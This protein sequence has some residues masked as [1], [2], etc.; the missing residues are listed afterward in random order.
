MRRLTETDLRAWMS[1]SSRKPLMLLGARQTG[2]TFLLR[3][4]LGPLFPASHYFSLDSNRI[5]AS[6]FDDEDLSPGRVIA[7][8]EMVGGRRI[9]SSRDLLILDEIQDCPRALASLKQFAQEMPGAFVCCA[10]S[11]LGLHLSDGTFP[12]GKVEFLDVR[13]MCFTEYLEA[14]DE[15]RLLEA[16]SGLGEGLKPSEAAHLLLWERFATYMLT[17]GMPEAVVAAIDRRET[18]LEAFQAARRIHLALETGYMAD[19][20]KHTGKPGS[21]QIERVWR[22]IPPQLGRTIDGNASR[23]RFSGVIPGKSGY[24]DLAGSIDWIEKAALAIRVPIVENAET[25][26]A[27]FARENAFKLYLHDTG[28]LCSMAGVGSLDGLQAARGSYR[29]WIAE[30]AV[31]Q[32][33]M[34]AGVRRPYSW[35]RATA[36]VEFLLEHDGKTIPVEV[37]A[38]RNSQAKSL[39]SFA[40]RYDPPL[41]IKAGM[42]NFSRRARTVLLPLYACSLLGSRVF[43]D[44]LMSGAPGP[45]S[46]S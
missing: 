26:L 7:G 32:E 43:L 46:R 29:G 13:P 19:M 42:W 4:Y 40:A 30:S 44:M 37:K 25:P 9:D 36:E 28:M 15:G 3:D 38:G 16:V 10:G 17:G 8:L 27:A 5:A 21:L 22:S 31:V 39:A 45:H 6:V 34:A 24:R 41:V 2:K 11:L 20:A 35:S 1:R 23:Y 14:L 18:P 12:V 33:L